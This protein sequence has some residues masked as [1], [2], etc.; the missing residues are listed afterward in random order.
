MRIPAIELYEDGR[1]ALYEAYQ[2]K[3]LLRG[4]DVNAPQATLLPNGVI[5]LKRGFMWDGP[6][7]PAVNTLNTAIPSAIHDA[8]YELIELGFLPPETRRS[9]DKTYRDSL[10]TWGVPAWRRALHYRGVSLFGGFW[11]R[12]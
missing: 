10:K 9:A 4:H 11:L 3:T 7:G 1:H 8:L 2:G 6:S 5:V 12:E